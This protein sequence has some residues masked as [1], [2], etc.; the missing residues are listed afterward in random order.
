[1]LIFHNI[2]GFV[3]IA[4]RQTPPPRK[5]N[6]F[7]FQC[8]YLV[9]I[10]YAYSSQRSRLRPNHEQ[11]DRPPP[12]I[13][14]FNASILFKFGMLILH[15]IPG[16]V[17]ITDRQ[18]PHPLPPKKKFLVRCMFQ[19]ILSRKKFLPCKKSKHF[20]KKIWKKISTVFFFD[21]GFL[22]F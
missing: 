14:F 15:N 3:P 5:K 18:T 2:P 1:M 8:S 21:F 16:F 6:I 11:T 19:T 17:P 7:F 9:Q 20:E 22:V 10:W 13:F 4:D 12:P